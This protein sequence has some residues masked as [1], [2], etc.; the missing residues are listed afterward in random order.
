MSRDLVTSGRARTTVTLIAI[1]ALG[2]ALRF[3]RLGQNSLWT[4]EI[5]SLQTAR[6]RFWTIPQA[7][8]RQDAFEPPLYFW[9]LHLIAASF[10]D[11]ETALRI[12]SA[13]SGALTIPLVWFL[14]WELSRQREVAT[15]S[16][17]FL[18]LNPLHLWYSQEARPYALMM[19]F[20]TAALF[21]LARALRQPSRW[22]WGAFAI[23]TGLA[24]MVHAV[25]CVVPIIAMLWV[26]FRADRATTVP[27]LLWAFGA[28][29]LL[30]APYYIPLAGAILSATGTGSPER[31][32]T[33]L[34]L[35]YTVF[36]YVGGYSFGPSVREIQDNG[37]QT[38]A[39]DHVV[40]LGL[41]AV[42][43]GVWLA[44]AIANRSSL[45]RQLLV[46]SALPAVLAFIGSAATTKAY[47]VRYTVLGLI[48]FVAS[49]SAVI[50]PLRRPLRAAVLA[51]FCAIFV[52]AD[53]QWFL[54]PRFRKDDSRAAIAWLGA[55][56]PS[57]ATVAVAPGYAI[58]GLAHY[59]G[60]S[61]VHLCLLAVATEDDLSRGYV[62]D[63]LVLTRLYHV[64]H[65]REL[66]AEFLRS[67]GPLLER[68][69]EIGY[70]LLVRRRSQVRAPSTPLSRPC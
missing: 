70:T 48:G 46:L 63:A 47:N 56:L 24:M 6:E 58:G 40:Q 18:A 57:G 22:L 17:T 50:V 49:V 16:A 13:I 44:P 33:G 15:L 7:A 34:E 55:H 42:V 67:A 51:T 26:L 31:S 2:A 23:C 45:M 30:V 1:S 54:T 9:L 37:W 32:L 53:A 68:G 35:P 27:P 36:T 38:A 29:L 43:L 62:P 61:G 66:E 3:Y 59:A 19:F 14:V 8:L 11:G 52:W 5:A 12:L 39:T 20:G 25:G 69:T 21:A 65:W 41:A 64:E 28:C 10:G 60:R 4:D